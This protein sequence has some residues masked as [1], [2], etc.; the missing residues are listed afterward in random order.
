[1]NDSPSVRTIPLNDTPQIKRYISVRTIYLDGEEKIVNI[2][3]NCRYRNSSAA[4]V[5]IRAYGRKCLK[6]EVFWHKELVP[7]FYQNGGTNMA[8]KEG[9]DLRCGGG[10]LADNY[11]C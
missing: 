9:F 5:F 2:I 10:H 11:P 4:A 7:P 6:S 1:M 8:E 3:A